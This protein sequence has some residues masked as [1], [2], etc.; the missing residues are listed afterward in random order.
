[1]SPKAAGLALKRGYKNIRVY[2]EGEPGWKEAGYCTTSTAGFI[3]TGNVILIDLRSPEAVKAGHI[4][5]AVGIPA[6]G[7]AA[8]RDKFPS[9]KGA[10]IVFYSDNIESLR[11]SVKTARGWGYR[12]TTIF[13]GGADAWKSQGLVLE[14][15][16]AA[17]EIRYARKISPGEISIPDFEK[18]VESGTATIVDVRTPTEFAAGHFKNA[19]NIPVDEIASSFSGLDKNR[20]ILAHCITGVRAEMAQSIL[21]EQGYDVK[22]LNAAPVFN[23]DGTYRINE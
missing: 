9:Y 23:Q 5:G 20:H 1:M 14:Q 21:K 16:A 7:L 3:K 15:G 18:A 22:F 13:F 4:P 10:N 12:N 8:A 17:P 11:A 19:V 6:E 2:L